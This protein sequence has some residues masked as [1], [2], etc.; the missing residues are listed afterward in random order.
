[1]DA[2]VH[3]SA[4]APKQRLDEACSAE[5]SSARIGPA[6]VLVQIFGDADGRRE[7]DG[8]GH[9]RLGAAFQPGQ[10]VANCAHAGGKNV[11]RVDHDPD[12]NRSNSGSPGMKCLPA[13]EVTARAVAGCD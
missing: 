1:M 2:V 5:L 7:F 12:A 8:S 9:W 4:T 6:R 13:G 11:L 3:V 10:R